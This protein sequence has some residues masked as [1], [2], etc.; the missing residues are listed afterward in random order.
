ME[1]CQK[2]QA[3][4]EGGARVTGHAADVGTTPVRDAHR[5]D[6]R[7]L[8]AWMTAHV[9][10]YAGPLTIEQFK[11]GQSNPTYRLRTPG[12]DYV[13]RRK[14]PGVL[15]KGAHDVLREARILGALADTDV[16]VAPRYGVCDD[17]AVIG[18][19]GH[20]PGQVELPVA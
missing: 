8:A 7:A 15:L 18:I 13:L 4:L 10:G 20:A 16:P 3:R 6:E 1:P 5:F 11:G 2:D 17:D 9:D 14:P 12:R 19:D